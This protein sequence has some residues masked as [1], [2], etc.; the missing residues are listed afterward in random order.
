[1]STRIIVRKLRS[2]PS[3]RRPLKLPWSQG[4]QKPLA[5]AA[6]SDAAFSSTAH[7]WSPAQRSAGEKS[8][9]AWMKRAISPRSSL[10]QLLDQLEPAKILHKPVSS[11]I[12]HYHHDKACLQHLS[13][14]LSFTTNS[15][16]SPWARPYPSLLVRSS[17]L[18][19]FD[20]FPFV[21]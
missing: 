9:W 20:S 6:A 12:N 15:W 7:A 17:L 8:A 2:I 11:T 1:M 4:I 21:S 16:P 19:R 13:E 5:S 3:S 10:E 14:H 18:L